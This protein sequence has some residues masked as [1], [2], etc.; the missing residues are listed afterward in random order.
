MPSARSSNA[1]DGR[2]ARAVRALAIAV[3]VGAA[4]FVVVASL[5]A[6]S[7]TIIEPRIVQDPVR[8]YIADYGK[9]ASVVLPGPDG[10]SVEYAYGEWGWF[11]LNKDQWWR[12]PG[13]VLLPTRGALGQS[14]WPAFA[15]ADDAH[16]HMLVER[17]LELV[18]ERERA[19]SLERRL[20]ERF[21]DHA[22]TAH[23]NPRYGL[24]FVHDAD[25][26]W[27]FN[28]CNT[29]VAA[30]VRELGCEV[31]GETLLGDF[32]VRRGVDRPSDRAE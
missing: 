17:V 9:H 26:Y 1:I 18:V 13:V 30:W 21:E 3:L 24:E 11:A 31:R 4:L 16:G 7:A 5:T 10:G 27:I 12:A 25:A 20:R 19:A 8:V 14:E 29:A 32:R 15:S 2:P 28:H 22:D 6:C 23:Y